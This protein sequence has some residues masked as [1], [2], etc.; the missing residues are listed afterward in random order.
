[1]SVSVIF[2]GFGAS[3]GVKSK[4]VHPTRKPAGKADWLASQARW[5]SRLT[6]DKFVL[7]TRETLGGTRAE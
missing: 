1:M 6:K 4:R 2:A 5:A 7:G 3:F